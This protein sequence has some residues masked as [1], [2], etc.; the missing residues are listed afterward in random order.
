MKKAIVLLLLLPLLLCSCTQEEQIAQLAF[1]KVVGIDKSENG[2]MISV[3]IKLPENELGQKIAGQDFLT[4]E[5]ATLAEGLNLIEALSESKIFYGQVSSILFGEGMARGGILDTVDFMMRSKDFRFDL[6]ILVVKNDTARHLIEEGT[7][8]TMYISEKIDALLA[9]AYS[10]SVSG[11]VQLSRLIEMMEDPYQSPYLP[12][13]DV[14]EDIAKPRLAGYCIFKQ[15]ALIQF[16]SREDSVGLN[17]LNNKVEDIVLVTQIKGGNITIKLSENKAKICFEDGIFKV[18]VSFL[19]E[20]LQSQ[21]VIEQFSNSVIEEIILAQNDAVKRIVEGCIG[22]LQKNRCDAA[23][24]GGCLYR[25]RPKTGK[26][27]EE[28]WAETFSG[29]LCEVE[30]ESKIDK[31]KSSGKPAEERGE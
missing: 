12:Y 28:K 20:V 22:T 19:S 23:D 11:E 21:R 14:S 8:E 30:V 13:I 7:G 27:Y 24:F 31:S 2:L 9:S 6:P 29:I 10:T 3:G 16:L 26:E 5:C 15:D 18:K 17:Y 1:V 25:S 4:V